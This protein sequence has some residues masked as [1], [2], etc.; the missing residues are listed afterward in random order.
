MYAERQTRLSK[1][2]IRTPNS[3]NQIYFKERTDTFNCEYVN[4]KNNKATDSAHK[5][6]Y[7]KQLKYSAAGTGR[8][9]QLLAGGKK[10]NSL[11]QTGHDTNIGLAVAQDTQKSFNHHM[12]VWSMAT[13]FTCQSVLGQ[14]TDPK[15]SPNVMPTVCNQPLQPA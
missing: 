5:S 4:S 3:Q 2:T 15:I 14:N 6:F 9:T 12:V 8:K 1:I 13:T 7:T 10:K 11:L